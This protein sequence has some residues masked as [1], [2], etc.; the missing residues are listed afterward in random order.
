M[1]AKLE[2][3]DAQEQFVELAGGAWGEIVEMDK[4]SLSAV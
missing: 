2:Y 3:Q 1:V 4:A